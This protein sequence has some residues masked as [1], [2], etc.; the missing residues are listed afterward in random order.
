MRYIKFIGLIC[1]LAGCGKSEPSEAEIAHGMKK[2]FIRQT[3]ASYSNLKT[4]ARKIGNGRWSVELIGDRYGQRRTLNATAV[5]DKNGD[6]HY[7]TD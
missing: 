6:I 4:R 3:G 2:S 5:M 7:Y 1:I